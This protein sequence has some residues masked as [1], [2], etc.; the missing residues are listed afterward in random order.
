MYRVSDIMFGFN[1]NP[2]GEQTMYAQCTTSNW[3]QTSIEDS[4]A[5]AVQRAKVQLLHERI[6]ARVEKQ[7]GE[8]LDAL[9][10]AVVEHARESDAHVDAASEK[11]ERLAEQID[12]LFG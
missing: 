3:S 8:Q 6:R 5:W 7:Y 10:D 12:R 9:A 1:E 4:A 11:R 2:T